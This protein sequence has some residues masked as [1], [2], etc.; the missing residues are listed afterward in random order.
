MIIAPTII[1]QALPL[2]SQPF[3]GGSFDCAVHMIV[4]NSCFGIFC[5]VYLQTNVIKRCC[6][7]QDEKDFVTDTI[8]F[9]LPHT[10]N[11]IKQRPITSPWSSFGPLTFVPSHKCFMWFFLCTF[12]QR[13]PFIVSALSK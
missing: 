11:P 3:F 7:F 4:A 8:I 13:I 5:I 10:I 2:G 12:R 1:N 6:S 9:T